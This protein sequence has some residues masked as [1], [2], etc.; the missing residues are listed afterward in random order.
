MVRLLCGDSTRRVSGPLWSHGALVSDVYV[1]SPDR[2]GH[3]SLLTEQTIIKKVPLFFFCFSFFSPFFFARFSFLRFLHRRLPRRSK[4]IAPL[5]SLVFLFSWGGQMHHVFLSVNKLFP[6]FSNRSSAFFSTASSFVPDQWRIHPEDA[7]PPLLLL[8]DG[9]P[10][11]V[12][13]SFFSLG[14]GC[15]K[16]GHNARFAVYGVLFRSSP[17]RA[18]LCHGKAAWFPAH[19]KIFSACLERMCSQR[20]LPPFAV[21]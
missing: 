19:C 18:I 16:H 8:G 12:F 17:R 13:G 4:P 14:L 11:G 2:G 5:S 3:G 9:L 15:W 1:S 20:W 6:L 10:Q 7:C 21:V